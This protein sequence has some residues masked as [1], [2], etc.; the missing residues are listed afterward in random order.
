MDEG[1]R[2]RGGRIGASSLDC[3]CNLARGNI[4]DV[5]I[6]PDRSA[7]IAALLRSTLLDLRFTSRVVR[8]ADRQFF[9][10]KLRTVS[11]IVDFLLH[12]LWSISLSANVQT[13][14]HMAG[15]QSM[16]ALVVAA[17]VMGWPVIHLVIA[18]FTLRLPP[19]AF[20]RDRFPFAG[21][22]WERE[23]QF[24]RR[25]LAIRRW[26]SLL[27]DG[28]PGWDDLQRSDS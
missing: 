23:G 10:T 14:S 9:Q 12:G 5:P 28:A 19:E 27:P 22:R 2:C 20:A 6:S 18:K 26:K 16:K 25:W 7:H 21:W 11:N 3:R 1:V 15:T 24:Y 13:A 17:N 4:R 8:S